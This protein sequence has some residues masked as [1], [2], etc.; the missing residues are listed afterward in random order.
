MRARRS[1]SPTRSSGGGSPGERQKSLTLATAEDPACEKKSV[2]SNA[3]DPVETAALDSKAAAAP[4]KQAQPETKPDAAEAPK[5]DAAG[6]S[7]D[8][9]QQPS[10]EAPDGADGRAELPNE[11]A[12]QAPWSEDQA[13]MQ[14]GGPMEQDEWAHVIA[15]TA[16]MRAEPSLQSQL[17]YALPA[18]WQVRVISRE[19]GWVQ[20]QDANSG[21]SGWIEAT[22]IAPG[23][24]PNAAQGYGRYQRGPNGG[25][26]SRYA[27]E[28]YPYPPPRWQRRRGEF[29]DFL[30]R[31]LGGF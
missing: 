18:G 27:D 28:G 8:G 15:G 16:D 4:Q 25:P 7:A 29:A 3:A 23:P 30:R 20:V 14:P 13:G 1:S 22:A 9:N 10:D 21:A 24:G 17:I 26:Y 19:P 6:E 2:A 12:A 31:A 11:D 5:P